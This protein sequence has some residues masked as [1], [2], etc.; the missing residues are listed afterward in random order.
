[1]MGM[2]EISVIASVGSQKLYT[3]FRDLIHNALPETQQGVSLEIDMV[4]NVGR[5]PINQS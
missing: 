1:M 3:K 4:V 2:E 5:K